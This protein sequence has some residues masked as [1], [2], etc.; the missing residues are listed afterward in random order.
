[1]GYLQDIVREV[2]DPLRYTRSVRGA[3]RKGVQDQHVHGALEQVCA[4]IVR[5]MI[6]GI[7]GISGV[8]L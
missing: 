6:R 3:Q 7:P 8:P 4:L 5:R 1:M 2:S